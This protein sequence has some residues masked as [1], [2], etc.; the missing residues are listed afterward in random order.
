MGILGRWNRN[1]DDEKGRRNNKKMT[2]TALGQ[3]LADI[4]QAY[5][6]LA[7][8]RVILKNENWQAPKDSSLYVLVDYDGGPI[9]SSTTRRDYSTN[10]EKN[11]TVSH[12]KFNIEVVS[13]GIDATN[14][15]KEVLQ[16]LAST[17]GIQ[18]AEAN[19]VSFFRAGQILD[20]SAIEGTASLRRYRIPVIIS[21]I[22]TKTV[23]AAM[24]DKFQA[25]ATDQNSIVEA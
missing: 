10:T 25:I 14:R 17:A 16:A 7:D 11:S 1:C 15:H 5:M 18:A 12:E 4:I 22:E 24:I 19:N 9:L 3:L 6:S 20:L 21:N 23:S 2:I 8:D 13:R